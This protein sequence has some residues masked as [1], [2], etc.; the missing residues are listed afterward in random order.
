MLSLK[1]QE[2]ASSGAVLNLS[3]LW[4]VVGT[5]RDAAKCLPFNFLIFNFYFFKIDKCKKNVYA[6]Q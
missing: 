1:K 4:A 6:T 2:C 5:G 3:N